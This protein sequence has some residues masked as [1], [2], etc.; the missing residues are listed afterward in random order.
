[1]SN[2]T[3]VIS[4]IIPVLNEEAYIKKVLESIAKNASKERV[5]EILVVDGGSADNTILEAS[6]FGARVI[7]SKKGRAAQMNLGANIASGDILYFFACGHLT[8]QRF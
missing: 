6:S 5:A 3:P 7:S 2:K 8:A 4:I 1:M